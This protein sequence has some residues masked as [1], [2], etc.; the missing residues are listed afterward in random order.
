MYTIVILHSGP[1]K[2]DKRLLIDLQAVYTC[3]MENYF[4]RLL[5]TSELDDPIYFAKIHQ[6]IADLEKQRIAHFNEHGPMNPQYVVVMSELNM[7]YLQAR[8]T[9]SELEIAQQIYQTSLSL[10][11][12]E[13]ERTLEAL[14][15]L[16]LSYLDD[17][18]LDEALGIAT[19]L[20]ALP[21]SQDS[22]SRYDLYIDALCFQADIQHAKQLYSQELVI[23]KHVLSLLE[24]LAGSVSSQAVMA[25]CG[26][27]FCL[28]KMK[29]YRQALD[30]YLVVRSYLDSEE[31]FA[32]EAEKIGLLV[33]IGRCYRK[34]GNFDDA[35]V[36]YHWAHNQATKHFGAA[37]TLAQKMKKL[38]GVIDTTQP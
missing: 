31:Q 16:G 4:A 25:R 9:S 23:R 38:V 27:A 26:L 7:A 28:E 29:K 20:L 1:A 18:Q 30:H 22:G 6:Q 32:T 2:T 34:L 10:Y 19:S 33:H 15:A 8:D 11:D 36:L 21:W 37:S 24:E 12:Q 13:D 17:N 3:C 35:T 14:L 5:L